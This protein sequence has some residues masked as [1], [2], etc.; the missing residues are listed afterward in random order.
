MD[1]IEITDAVSIKKNPRPRLALPVGDPA[2]IGIEVT[3]QALNDPKVTAD[4]DVTVIGDRT[5]LI[6]PL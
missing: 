6:E 3:L 1:S 5:Q 4:C 2:G